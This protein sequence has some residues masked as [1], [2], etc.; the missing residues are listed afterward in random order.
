MFKIGVIPLL[1]L[2]LNYSPWLLRLEPIMFTLTIFIL[3]FA[4]TCLIV[5]YKIYKNIYDK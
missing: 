4:L 1:G 5:K 3:I 2:L